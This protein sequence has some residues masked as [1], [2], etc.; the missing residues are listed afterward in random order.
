MLAV[1]YDVH[2]NLAALDAVLDEA[3]AADADRFVL[4]GDYCIYGPWPRETLER[5]QSLPEASWIRGN[6]DRALLGEDDLFGGAYNFARDQ[7]G[8][9]QV[10]WL[11]TLPERVAFGGE[12]FCHASPLSD[13]ET[14]GPEPGLDDQ[15]LLAGERRRVIVF[16]HSHVQFRRPGPDQT[17]LVNPGSVGLPLDG[18]TRAAWALRSPDGSIELRRTAYDVDSAIARLAPLGTE[19]AAITARRLA[20]A[21]NG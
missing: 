21:Q 11:H 8:R 10:E 7:L 16:G 6:T 9:E 19:W 12:L 18:D 3:R 15:R 2:G 5:L 14:F 1:L 13:E 20:S 4:G 17:D